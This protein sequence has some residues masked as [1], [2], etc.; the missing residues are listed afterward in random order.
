VGTGDEVSIDDD[1]RILDPDR[2][3]G[4]RVGLH[5]EIRIGSG[6][7]EAGHAATCDDVGTGREQRAPADARDHTALRVDGSHEGRDA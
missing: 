1:R 4:F 5:D 6:V 7:V 3:G 2:P